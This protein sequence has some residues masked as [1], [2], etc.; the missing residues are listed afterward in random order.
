MNLKDI[1]QAAQVSPATV[2]LVLHNKKGVNK[3]TRE[4]LTELLIQN[5]YVIESD[6][7][8]FSQ[9]RSIRF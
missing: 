2:S 5:G 6:P 7:L 1:A 4:R 9:T 8:P 3:E